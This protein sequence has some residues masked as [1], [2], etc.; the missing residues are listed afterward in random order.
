[1]VVS[2]MS[3]KRIRLPSTPSASMT[4]EVAVL[5]LF[6]RRRRAPAGALPE[7]TECLAGA[8]VFSSARK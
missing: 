5:K 7:I 8:A 1:M 6:F 2:S 3:S 4:G